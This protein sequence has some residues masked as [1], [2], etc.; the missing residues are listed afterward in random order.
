MS[1]TTYA[2]VA[3]DVNDEGFFTKPEQW[4]KDIAAELAA[5]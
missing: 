4:T 3:V 5:R 2:G 1:T